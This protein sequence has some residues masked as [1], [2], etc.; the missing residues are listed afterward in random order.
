MQVVYEND[1]NDLIALSHNWMENDEAFNKKKFW[2][3]YGSPLFILL[4]ISLLAY[5]TNQNS[6]YGGAVGGALGSYLWTLYCY[7]TYAKKSAKQLQQ[8]EIFCKHTLTISS[9]GVREETENSDNYQ[10]WEAIN[11]IAFT[12][13]HIFIYNTPIT[14]HIIPKNMVGEND[15]VKIQSE[16]NG[17][18]NT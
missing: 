2:S 6:F 1:L 15:F 10:T 17:Y 16:I 4:A 9:S 8:K 18:K 12:D 7:K 14:A 3:L 5:I 13:D 11:K